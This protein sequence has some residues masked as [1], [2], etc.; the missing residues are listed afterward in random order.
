MTTHGCW[1]WQ[2]ELINI[3]HAFKI[4][5]K[6]AYR[7]G[8]LDTSRKKCIIVIIGPL[9]MFCTI[10]YYM[11]YKRVQLFRIYCLLTGQTYTGNWWISETAPPTILSSGTKSPLLSPFFVLIAP[12]L[13][14]INTII[15]LFPIPIVI[16]RKYS[17][18]FLDP[19]AS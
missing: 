8:T 9:P 16:L 13:D 15:C 1:F 5:F 3:T 2:Y 12:F 14:Q 10:S 17:S 7:L 4:I 18:F 11:C 19:L 6:L